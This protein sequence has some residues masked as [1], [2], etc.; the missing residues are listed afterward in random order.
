[1]MMDQ[2]REMDMEMNMDQMM[3]KMQQ[4]DETMTSMMGM[5]RKMAM[6]G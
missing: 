6:N 4:C 1:M 5:M 3:S 2:M